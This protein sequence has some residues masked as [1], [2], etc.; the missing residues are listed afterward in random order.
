MKKFT[1]PILIALLTTSTPCATGGGGDEKKP[2]PPKTEI[3]GKREKGTGRLPFALEREHRYSWII[4]RDKVGEVKVKISLEDPPKGIAGKKIYRCRSQYRHERDGIILSGDHDVVFDLS[5]QPLSFVSHRNF[6]GLLNQVSSQVQ[7]GRV[8][9]GQLNFTV[10]HNGIPQVIPSRLE[11]P[12]GGYL[13]LSNT[14]VEHFAILTSNVLRRPSTYEATVIYPPLMRVTRLIFLF[15]GE[16]KLDLGKKE[17]T[18]CWMFSFRADSGQ[19][20]GKVWMD[21]KGRMVQY[22]QDRTKI[23]LEE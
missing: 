18:A 16:E 12:A 7:L 17:K 13:W 23:I 5:W 14:A 8:E 19:L 15:E 22:Q 11:A 2:E 9:G 6:K 21:P 4:G 20:K 1:F 3:E 10:A